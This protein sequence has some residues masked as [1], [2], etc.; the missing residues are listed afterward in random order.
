MIANTDIQKLYAKSSSG[1]TGHNHIEETEKEF[2]KIKVVNFIAL[3][4]TSLILFRL[5]YMNTF[6]T[7][8]L[9][10][11]MTARIE[12]TVKV[13]AMRGT[14]VDRNGNPLA[15][16]TPVAAIW[17]DPAEL[18]NLSGSQLKQIANI[19]HMSINEL[20]TKLNQKDKTFVYIKREVSPEQAN[21]IKDLDIDGIYSIQEFKRYYPSGEITA[22]VVGFNNVD[23][24]GIN[25]IEYAKNQDL[26]GTNGSHEIIRDRQGHVVEDLGTTKV[27]QDGKTVTL[28]IDNR[29]QYIAYNAL[30]TQVTKL[31]AAGGSAIVLDAKTGE[32]LSMV[33]MPTY[34]PNNRIGVNP[35]ML[36]NTAI[37][38][39]YDPGSI[40][41]PIVI[42]KALDDK[43]VTPQTIID[44][45][46]YFVGP[47]LI[48]DDEPAS[49]LSVED[50]LI[51]SSDIGTSK[52][53]LKY[54][55]K[56]LYDYYRSV[57]LGGKL[58]TGFPGEASGIL[59]NS[60]KVRPMDQ[61][62][63]SFGYG[64]SVSLLQMAHAYTEFTNKGCI[65]PITFYK[66]NDNSNL[67]CKQI[68][69]PKAADIIRNILAEN[70]V[71]GTGK[72]AQLADYT[73]AGKTGTA[74]KI[75]NGHYSNH[76]H[77]ASFVGFAPATSP[78]IIVA[79]MVDNPK[80]SYYGAAVSAPVFSEIAGPTLH[81]LGVHP[82]HQ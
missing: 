65:L 82:D 38:N 63:N 79:V 20:N 59:L 23:D 13:I 8:F 68:I 12:R 18:D 11:Q 61:A 54:N 74:Q 21:K 70:T 19:L 28:S 44:T 75:I 3:I 40:M 42:A 71:K 76:D 33:N 1:F 67:Q 39:V 34:N 6:N 58:N 43:I 55:P 2:S 9:A 52:I 25:G 5:V 37:T 16:S 26:I 77:I 22:H 35:D 69:S 62:L 24:R 57:G 30:K 56:V 78:R 15:V 51:R 72:N 50:I 60:N 48:K 81:L 45:H 32:V 46:Q 17:V 36:K 10:K 27:A 31:H 7:L 53:A 29:I 49:Q 80:G 4:L 64:I 73:T 14:I 47:K 41:K 66:Q